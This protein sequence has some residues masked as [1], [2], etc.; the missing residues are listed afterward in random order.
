MSRMH[1]FLITSLLD[2]KQL[3]SHG[4]SHIV[5]CGFIIQRGEVT[6]LDSQ[7][8]LVDLLT[9]DQKPQLYTCFGVYL[10]I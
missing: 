1:R 6:F 4:P 5:P 3:L 2:G 8:N 10:L 9:K 7:L